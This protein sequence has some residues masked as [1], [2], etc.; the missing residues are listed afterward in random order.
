ML[1]GQKIR[2]IRKQKGYSQK[3]MAGLLG[4][5]QSTIANYEKET[6][7]PSIEMLVAMSDLFDI[8]VD[9]LLGLRN[10]PGT[11]L[12]DYDHMSQIQLSDYLLEL[13]LNDQII[14]AKSFVS[15]YLNHYS[16]EE[17]LMVLIRYV[18]TKLGWLWEVSEITIAR[19]HWISR[20][21]E[22]LIE[23]VDGLAPVENIRRSEL[24][25][26]ITAP[27]E[28]HTMGLKMM[29]ILL[30]RMGYRVHFVGEG[31]PIEDFKSYVKD[32]KPDI[33][34]VSI[35]S[36]HFH[37]GAAAYLKSCKC[38]KFLLGQG[39]KAFTAYDET[40]VLEHYDRCLE[41]LR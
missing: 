3:D 32:L 7:Q 39:V 35:T 8:T 14:Q 33:L 16:L 17:T 28:K 5:T 13:L 15:E 10:L 36:P 11:T 24:V 41:A 30:R 1:L 31:V 4:V 25:L 40:E 34:L 19:E 6:R 27:G 9:E 20:Q 38:R 22:T 2:N 21:V 26:G 37:D 29:M 23:Y 18:L 12:V